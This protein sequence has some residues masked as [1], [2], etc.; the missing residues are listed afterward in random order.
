M[1]QIFPENA[2][3]RVA[4]IGSGPTGIY[5]LK[6]LLS[7]NVALDITLFEAQ[8]EA[9]KG[10]PYHQDWNEKE[11][12][13]NIASIELPPVTQTLV[14][15]LQKK[16]DY[17]LAKM[18]ITRD[19]IDERT[20]FPRVVLGNYF[21]DELLT[22][23][24]NNRSQSTVL[25][26]TLHRVMDILILGDSIELITELFEKTTRS[27]RFD[28]CIMATGHVWPKETETK[29]G[30]FLS[31]WP[32]SALRTIG[33]CHVG[34][35]GTS[36][37][38]I[39]AM[40]ALAVSRGSFQR[41]D[42]GILEYLPEPGTEAF[43]VTMISRKGILPEADF[44][45]P[46]PYE[47]LKICTADAIDK[48]VAES[49]GSGLLDTVFELFKAEIIQE[50]AE[51]ASHV[52]LHALT[53]E[54]FA[55][56]YFKERQEHDP[57]VW[58]VKN[59]AEAKRNQERQH[60]VKWRYAILRMHEVVA[61]IVPKLLTEDYKRFNRF[62]KHIFVDD[63][64]TVPH[65][66]IERLLAMHN[67]GKLEIL[68]VGEEYTI[69]TDSTESGAVLHKENMHMY[70]PAFIEAIGQR[71]L[72]VQD[73]PF[74]SLWKQGVLE[75]ATTTD[76]FYTQSRQWVKKKTETNGLA[77]DDAFHPVS[78]S[79]FSSQ[80]YCL[81]LPFLLGQ[82]PFSQG[83]TSSHE[84]GKKVAQDLGAQLMSQGTSGQIESLAI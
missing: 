45:Y 22:L 78:R 60:T 31:P 65:E 64:A 71:P 25:L 74:P 7:Q 73:F 42:K 51:Y 54:E 53:L 76:Y 56:V 15:W 43:R 58:A 8:A 50:D 26:K 83:I 47:S 55:A 28:Y 12:L 49:K 3:T 63:Y 70:F 82:F 36:L 84:M 81:S 2:L 62:F 52:A 35:K 10:T 18:G 29:S 72:S 23:L 69:D 59:L 57:F 13:A 27:Y 80:L 9:G 21:H 1:N 39:D 17:E 41:D 40:V 19:K 5:A 68:R 61:R 79:P 34:I 16:T 30:Y 38:A 14:S 4:I 11:M 37:S 66:S 6:Y 20:F 48:L 24:A 46:I 77:L 44:F 32:S 67:A 75:K 33:N